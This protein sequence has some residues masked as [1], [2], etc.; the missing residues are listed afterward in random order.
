VSKNWNERRDALL[1]HSFPRHHAQFAII[2]EENTEEDLPPWSRRVLARCRMG[3]AVK[4]TVLL[5][6]AADS[7]SAAAVKYKK[8]VW[9]R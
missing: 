7:G 6:S 2:C 1:A 9:L 4:K 3:T 8:I 5:A